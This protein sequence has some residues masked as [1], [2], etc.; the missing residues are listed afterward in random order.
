[1]WGGDLINK[2]NF[3]IYGSYLAVL[4]ILAVAV[5]V[6]G[7]DKKIALW[8]TVIIGAMLIALWPRW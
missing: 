2:R 3:L 6:F 4:A 7:M 5:T 1:M 8:A